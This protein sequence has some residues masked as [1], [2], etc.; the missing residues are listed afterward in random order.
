MSDG[1]PAVIEPRGKSNAARKGRYDGGYT[2]T[3]QRTKDRLMQQFRRTGE[4]PGAPSEA[5]RNASCWCACGRLITR[6]GMC[7]R[8]ENAALLDG[9]YYEKLHAREDAALESLRSDTSQRMFKQTGAAEPPPS[10]RVTIGDVTYVGDPRMEGR[11]P[12]MLQVDDWNRNSSSD[13]PQADLDRAVETLK[14]P[15]QPAVVLPPYST[16]KLG[17]P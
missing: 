15:H 8:C 10:E 14:R 6:N 5:Y 13:D 4:G 7:Q 17:R 16:K 1:D 12:M 9:T 2:G 11:A 3:E